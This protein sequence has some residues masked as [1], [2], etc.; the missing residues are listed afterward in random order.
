MQ[1]IRIMVI[2]RRPVIREGIKQILETAK[3]MTIK[4][5]APT[6]DIAQD[7]LQDQPTDVILLGNN[8]FWLF[9]LSAIRAIKS[10]YPQMHV[11]LLLDEGGTA[12]NGS[13]LAK[14]V[15]CFMPMAIDG[16]RLANI[17]RGIAKKPPAQGNRKKSIL[18]TAWRPH[19]CLSIREL[20]VVSF[21]AR[22]YTITQ[23]ASLMG[24]S[25]KTV[26]TYRQRALVKLGCE[27]NAQL[28]LYAIKNGL[29]DSQEN[30]DNIKTS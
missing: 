10:K 9:E 17:I 27:N 24:L 20:Q 13:P 21:M 16:I 22:G 26:S 30:F 19:H 2:E 23:V 5:E 8:D 25:H 7:L 12:G 1:K 3:D 29:G 4:A 6:G 15:D 28:M 18:M 11:I 14:Y